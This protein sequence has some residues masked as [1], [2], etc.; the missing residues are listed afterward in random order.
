MVFGGEMI[1]DNYLNLDEQWSLPCALSLKENVYYKFEI[2]I[3]I[4]YWTLSKINLE[5]FIKCKKENN[6]RNPKKSSVQLMIF[7]LIYINLLFF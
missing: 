7:I 3:C 4:S 6:K 2:S 5:V 1:I